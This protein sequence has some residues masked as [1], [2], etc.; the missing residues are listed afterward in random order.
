MNKK[1]ENPACLAKKTS[2]KKES[3]KR[4]QAMYLRV[5]SMPFLGLLYY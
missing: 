4:Q 1:T 2:E 5:F 3:C